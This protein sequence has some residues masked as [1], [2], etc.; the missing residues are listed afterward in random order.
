[1][2]ILQIAIVWILL[3]LGVAWVFSKH[4]QRMKAFDAATLGAHHA[5]KQVIQRYGRKHS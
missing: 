1:M 5:R 4:Q 2:L 3:S